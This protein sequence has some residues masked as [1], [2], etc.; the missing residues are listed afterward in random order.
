MDERD[1]SFK[2]AH[3]DLTEES[4]CKIESPGVASDAAWYCQLQHHR[5]QPL[6]DEV[7]AIHLVHEAVSGMLE[8]VRCRGS[9]DF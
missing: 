8:D 9:A 4:R 5:L 6:H 7:D 2:D 3:L 1:M